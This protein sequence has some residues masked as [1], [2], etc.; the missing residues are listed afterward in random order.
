VRSRLGHAA[1]GQHVPQN[2]TVLEHALTQARYAE[3][4]QDL[5]LV[6]GRVLAAYQ[7]LVELG[8]RHGPH[9][10][11]VVEKRV[12]EVV[13]E[14][15]GP[16]RRVGVALAQQDEV[17]VDGEARVLGG[18][19]LAVE[20][21]RLGVDDEADQTRVEGMLR[22]QRRGENGIAHV[23]PVLVARREETNV[24]HGTLRRVPE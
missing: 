13:Q 9:V 23:I 10:V 6:R 21:R 18:L 8:L 3:V 17:V 14:V 7:G 4:R 22:Q 15:Q 1:L 19:A 20:D 16:Q 24:A 2:A 5:G 12:D 11:R